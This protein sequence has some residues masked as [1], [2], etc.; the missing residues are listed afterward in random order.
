LRNREF[1]DVHRV[2][3]ESRKLE[4]RCARLETERD[5]ARSE[6]KVRDEHAFGKG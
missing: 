1:R 5:E 6:L 2:L 3:P 4:E